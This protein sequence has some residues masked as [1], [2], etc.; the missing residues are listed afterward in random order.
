MRGRFSCGSG[1]LDV[2][3]T[4][5]QRKVELVRDGFDPTAIADPLYFL[6]PDTGAYRE[7]AAVNYA[8]I[9]DGSIRL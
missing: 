7:L 3:E 5:K 9:L 8:R 1:A 4:F 6:D 2:T